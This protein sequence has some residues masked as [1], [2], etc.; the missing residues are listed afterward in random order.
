MADRRLQASLDRAR[1]GRQTT[2]ELFNDE[3]ARSGLQPTNVVV[4]R[5]SPRAPNRTESEK[6]DEEKALQEMAAFERAEKTQQLRQ[7]FTQQP[8]QTNVGQ[9]EEAIDT[10]VA[11][12]SRSVFV[13]M[14]GWHWWQWTTLQLSI[15]LLSIM[16]LGLAYGLESSWLG[17]VVGRVAGA[18][19][20]VTS[21][22]GFD[23]SLFSP[24]NMFWVLYIFLL[25]MMWLSL[26][27][28]VVTYMCVQH[29]ALS[30]KRTGLKYGTVALALIGY[31]VP[32]ANLFPWVVFYILV[33][34]RYPR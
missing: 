31:A 5:R 15:G 3:Y 25:G 28:T 1:T 6:L 18:V 11:L 12:R 14:M 8:T 22:V 4:D 13:W 19:N 7:R 30:G 29:R 33:M 17:R 32:I 34:T 20:A 24:E 10:A 16:F 9:A 27:A 23:F 21:F 26:F 2:D